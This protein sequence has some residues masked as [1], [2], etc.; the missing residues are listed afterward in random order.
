MPNGFLNLSAC[1]VAGGRF[2]ASLMLLVQVRSYLNE[3]RVGGGRIPFVLIH[4]FLGFFESRM[5]L[6]AAATAFLT[7]SACSGRKV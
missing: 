2:P 1:P 5:G 3:M 7:K 4:T 6:A